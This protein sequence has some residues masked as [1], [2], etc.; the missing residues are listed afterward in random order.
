MFKSCSNSFFTS[1]KTLYGI[2]T[3]N[4]GVSNSKF[5]NKLSKQYL[6]LTQKRNI[7]FKQPQSI[8]DESMID[9]E[10]RRKLYSFKT[11]SLASIPLITLGL[12]IW[13]YKRLEYKK[14]LIDTIA[15]KTR[16]P[17]IPLPLKLSQEYF[18][19]QQYRQVYTYGKFDHSK[20]MLVGI[21]SKDGRAGYIVVTPLEREDG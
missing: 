19:S 18:D 7:S 3:R 12:G 21:V 1:P 17:P 13:Q 4:S 6:K 11:L 2:F 9:L 20:E 5:S 16:A 15:L 8:L 10:W 14:E